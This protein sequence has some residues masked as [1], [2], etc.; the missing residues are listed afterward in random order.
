M[1]CDLCAD[2]FELLSPAFEL[3]RLVTR[4]IEDLAQLRETNAMLPAHFAVLLEEPDLS[5]RQNRNRTDGFLEHSA[6]VG[7][8]EELQGTGT[9]Q[10]SHDFEV[11]IQGPAATVEVCRQS[12]RLL[13]QALR[14]LAALL[15]QQLDFSNPRIGQ[16]ELSIE[17]EPLALCGLG[18]DGESPE[19]PFEPTDSLANR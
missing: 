10:Q 7:I 9:P 11:L 5:R 1:T 13:S 18:L 2:I 3:A 17:L 12:R 14:L 16:L 19:I 4:L 15:E 6:P 8:D